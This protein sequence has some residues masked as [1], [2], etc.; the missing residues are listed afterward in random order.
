MGVEHYLVCK[1]CKKYIDL[2]KAYEFSRIV[3]RERP[4][5]GVKNQFGD[6]DYLRGN[7]WETRGLWFLWQHRE[8]CP[9]VTM[10]T[11]DS[12]E[13]Y[14]E[15]PKLAEVFPHDKDLELRKQFEPKE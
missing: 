14:D 6:D 9:G 1:S 7:Y 8:H 11:D 2:H 5:I 10:L 13:W 15:V 4:P 12:D 3:H